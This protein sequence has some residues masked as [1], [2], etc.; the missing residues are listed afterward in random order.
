MTFGI[1]EIRIVS[2]EAVPCVF[3][4]SSFEPN[5]VSPLSFIFSVISFPSL[6]NTKSE[7]KYSNKL[8]LH[9]FQISTAYQI[10]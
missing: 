6:E 2:F 1:S 9:N 8:I 4:G 7:G 5:S 3:R 10:L